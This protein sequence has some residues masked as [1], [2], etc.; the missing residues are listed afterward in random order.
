MRQKK[1]T[2]HK[3]NKPARPYPSADGSTTVLGSS[4]NGSRGNSGFFQKKRFREFQ[5]S[6]LDTCR[7]LEG[8][9]GD[10]DDSGYGRSP[11]AVELYRRSLP[12]VAAE[13]GHIGG[14]RDVVTG[15]SGM[16]IGS[17]ASLGA[18]SP[19]SPQDTYS[20]YSHHSGHP[21]HSQHDAYSPHSHHSALSPHSPYDAYSHHSHQSAAVSPHSP[22]DA[23]SPLDELR[24]DVDRD[25]Q[26]VSVLEEGR[27]SAGMPQRRGSSATSQLSL[28][29]LYIQEA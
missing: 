13:Q 27:G 18:Y 25:S 3:E 11:G 9:D 19:H 15:G 20:Q 8:L 23:Y 2:P 10:D 17:G 12:D 24:R 5:D 28:D 7:T 29:S 26:G 4:G 1:P 6:I 21:A 22:H 14:L 16:V